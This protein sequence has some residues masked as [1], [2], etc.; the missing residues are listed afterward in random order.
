MKKS[1][2]TQSKPAEKKE[3]VMK[4][5]DCYWE[6]IDDDNEY[7]GYLHVVSTVDGSEIKIPVSG[8]ITELIN[9]GVIKQ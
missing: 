5:A 4:K 9:A 2:T 7:D 3:S 1:I 8:I 6:I